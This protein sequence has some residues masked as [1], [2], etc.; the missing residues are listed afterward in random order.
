MHGSAKHR[1]SLLDARD[2]P[3]SIAAP[4][5]GAATGE[6]SRDKSPGEPALSCQTVTGLPVG[7]VRS[8]LGGPAE[9]SILRKW[10]VRLNSSPD[11]AR[12]EGEEMYVPVAGQY[13]P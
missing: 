2:L 6:P 13:P 1:Q 8:M 12:P 10:S 5:L 11:V 7:S 9:I 3:H 4:Q